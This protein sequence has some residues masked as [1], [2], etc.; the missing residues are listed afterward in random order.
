MLLDDIW[1]IGDPHFGIDFNKRGTPLARRGEREA[2][3]L[4]QFKEELREGTRMNVMVG[5]LFDRAIVDLKIVHSVYDAYAEAAAERPEVQFVLMAGNHDLFRQLIDTKTGEPLRG[6]FHALARMLQHIPN[7]TVLF[8][9]AVI[10]GVAF[11]PWQWDVTA[12][13]QVK[14]IGTDI[15]TVAVGHWDLV[16]YGGSSDHLCPRESLAALGVSTLISGHVH[17][18]GSYSG[19]DCTGSMQP[20]T[21]AE[22]RDGRMYRTVTLEELEQ[23]PEDDLYN[24]NIRVLLEPGQ[25]LP[26]VNC[27][28]LTSKRVGQPDEVELS[29]VNLGGFDLKVV[30]GRNMEDLKIPTPVRDFV[31]EKIGVID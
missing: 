15:P 24:L 27:L 26:E 23:I 25:S 12:E 31:W 10:D 16:E 8:E 14:N 7:V 19:V 6:S 3:Q 29:D 18:A 30:L 20:Y 28:S 2:M 5:D 13:E 4:A 22:D 21:H 1:F 17:S 11:F 9:P